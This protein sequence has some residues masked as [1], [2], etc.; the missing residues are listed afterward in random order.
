MD[1]KQV[2]LEAWFGQWPSVMIAYSGGVD[3]AL[4]MAIGQRVLG[5][6]SLACIGTSPSYPERELAS[7]L[8][9]AKGTG[10]NV[11]VVPTEEH[12]DPRY[13][14]NPSNRCYFCKS[15]LYGRL[16]QVAEAE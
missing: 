7:A 5:N 13:A 1:A 14:A 3:S 16:K 6:K 15:E 4:L 10:A 2:Q 11:R 12:L 9:V 8:E